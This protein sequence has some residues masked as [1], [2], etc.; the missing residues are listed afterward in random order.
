MP[1]LESEVYEQMFLFKSQIARRFADMFSVHPQGGHA[2]LHRDNYTEMC[3]AGNWTGFRS[4]LQAV[5]RYAYSSKILSGKWRKMPPDQ[6]GCETLRSP[7]CLDSW[8]TD[9]SAVV[10]ALRP[11]RTLAHQILWCSHLLG[12]DPTPESR[13]GWKNQIKWEE[14]ALTGVEPTTFGI[15]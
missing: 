12:T 7:H 14:K 6:E 15:T 11:G 10:I 8:L 4:A 13:C 3:P 2:P 9:G 1:L 5:G